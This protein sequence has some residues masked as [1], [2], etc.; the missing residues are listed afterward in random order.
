MQAADDET[1]RS[2]LKAVA[3][4]L[5]PSVFVSGGMLLV[6][7]KRVVFVELVGLSLLYSYSFLMVLI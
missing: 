5:G 4:A 2:V 1:T 7:Y 6:S 3:V